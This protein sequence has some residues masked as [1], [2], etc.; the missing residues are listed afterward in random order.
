[1]LLQ[2]LTS[3]LDSAD[4]ST[5]Q[6]RLA[7]NLTVDDIFNSFLGLGVNANIEKFHKG[8]L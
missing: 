8:S 6:Q 3:R 5:S 2:G 7:V 1:M 4:I